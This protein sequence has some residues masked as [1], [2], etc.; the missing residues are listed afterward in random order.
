MAT[1][2]PVSVPLSSLPAGVVCAAGLGCDLVVVLPGF[3]GCLAWVFVRE[4]SRLRDPD[5]CARR[6]TRRTALR[7]CGPTMPSVAS[8]LSAWKRRTAVSVSGPKRP[9]TPGRPRL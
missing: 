3:A 7:V 1:S 8:P 2:H 6:S 5:R 4:P 9:S